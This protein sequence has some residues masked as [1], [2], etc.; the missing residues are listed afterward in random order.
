MRASIPDVRTQLAKG[1]A[2]K[3][4][5]GPFYSIKARDFGNVAL[6]S[7]SWL[8]HNFAPVALMKDSISLIERALCSAL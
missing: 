1:M 7:G 5:C 8:I 4:R 2:A 6:C 3:S